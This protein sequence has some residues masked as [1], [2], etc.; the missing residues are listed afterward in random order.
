MKKVSSNAQR[1]IKGAVLPE[2]VPELVKSL[3]SHVNVLEEYPDGLDRVFGRH[4]R[5]NKKA[6]TVPAGE[7]ANWSDL[8]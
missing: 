7:C 1:V 2:S 5:G 8:K 6:Q 3:S 4:H